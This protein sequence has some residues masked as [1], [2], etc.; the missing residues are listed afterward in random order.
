MKVVVGYHDSGHSEDADVNA[1]GGCDVAARE[2]LFPSQ[3]A[4]AFFGANPLKL[5]G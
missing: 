5:A 4:F 1:E 2:R 3:D